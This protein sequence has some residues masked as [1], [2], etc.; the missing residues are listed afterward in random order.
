MRHEVTTVDQLRPVAEA[1]VTADRAERRHESD[2]EVQAE[3]HRGVAEAEPEP[4]RGRA[5]AVVDQ[6]AADALLDTGA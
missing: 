2:H 3:H 4:D 1:L 6:L 5:L